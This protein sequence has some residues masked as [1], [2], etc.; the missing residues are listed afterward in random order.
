MFSRISSWCKSESTV[1]SLSRDE[2][3]GAA[4]SSVKQHPSARP[5]F[6][7]WAQ[8]VFAVCIAGLALFTLGRFR[9]ALVWGGVLAIVCWPIMQWLGRKWSP[10]HAETVLPLAVVSAIA[11]VFVIPASFLIGSAAGE[12]QEGGKWI[13]QAGETGVP[14]PVWLSKLPWGRAQIEHWWQTNLSNPEGVRALVHKLNPEQALA[15]LEHVGHGVA[16]TV[17]ILCFA[18]LILFFLLRGGQ[19]LI[20]H[21]NLFILRLLGARGRMAQKQLVGAVRGAMAGLVLVG[22]GEGVIIGV[23]YIIAGAP[24]PLLLGLF[25][26]LASMIPMVGGVAVAISALLIAVKGSL[27]AGIAV[28]VFGFVI[29]F[30]AD[31]FIRP[32]LIGGS[33]RL[34]FVWVLLGILGGIETW[35]LSGLFIGPVLMA[36]AHLIWRFGSMRANGAGEMIGCQ[37]KQ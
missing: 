20:D 24:Q 1:P 14:E 36:L 37:P 21:L 17:V 12:A 15:T 19:K 30:L 35:G 31:H 33:I 11:L 7:Y 6:Q 2:E 23:S 32:V 9:L 10:K 18:L 27:G 29:L 4:L 34:P 3:D 25:T 16:N 26:A 5:P 28:G 22:L 13:R 8:G